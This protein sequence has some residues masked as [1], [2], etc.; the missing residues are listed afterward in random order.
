MHPRALPPLALL[1]VVLA[2]ALPAAAGAATGPLL[3]G[4]TA[5][6]PTADQN[7]AGRAEA[8][9]ASAT[10]SGTVATV[11]V[12]VDAGSPATKLTA[13]IYADSAGKPGALLAQGT[14]DAPVAARWNDVAVT[15]TTLTSGTSYW[16]AILSP[17]GSGALRFRDRAGGG[18]SEASASATLTGLPGTWASGTVYNDS[19]VSAY[20]SAAASTQPILAVAPTSLTFTATTGGADPAAQSV[21]VSN[22]GGG[23]LSFTDAVDSPWLSAT[24]GSGTAPAT[25]SVAPHVAGLAA[26]T[27]NGKVTVTATGVQGSP[28]DVA[29][30]LTVTDPAPPPPPP[31]PSGGDWLQIQHDAARTGFASDE[32]TLTAASAKRLAQAWATAV[33]GK[34]TAA[35]LFVSAI[36]AGGQ[37]RD[38]VVVATAGDSLYAVDAAT[39]TVV[40]RRN[41]GAVVSNCAIPGGF[42]ISASPAID[43]ARGRI[44]T[45]TEDGRLRTVA[46]ADGTDA[47]PAVALV[48][49]P[50]TNRV[51]GGLTLVGSHLYVSTA[52][53][54]CDT[55]PWRGAVY[56]VDVSGASPSPT[57]SWTVVPGIAAPNGGGGIWGYGGVSAD[58]ATGRVYG[59]TG[60]DSAEGYQLYADRLVALDSSLSLLGSWEPTHPTSFP[61][62]GAPCDVDFGA[63]PLVFQPSGCP[64]MVAA[65][66]KDGLLYVSKASTLAAGGAPEQQI[67]LNPAN[68]W[69]G[70]GGVGGTPAWWPDGRTV[71]VSE[72]GPGVTGVNGGV[73]ALS[74]GADCSLSVAWSKALGVAPNP[75]STPTV[76]NGVVYVGEGGSGRTVAFDAQTGEQLWASNGGGAA[77]AAPIV[78]KGTVFQGT[79]DGSSSGDKGTLRAFRPTATAAGLLLGDQSVEAQPDS[80]PLGMAE[81]FQATAS[82]SGTLSKLSV[83]LDTNNSAARLVVG[84]YTDANNHPGSLVVQ[85]SIGSLVNGAF[86]DVP[87]AGGTLVSATKYWIAVLGG[88]SGTLRFRDRAGGCRSETSAQTTLTALP[89]TWSTGVGYPDCPLSG[90]GSGS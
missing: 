71:F 62:N 3:V 7:A 86:N 78:A 37:T 52:S 21:G 14:L 29:V 65:G 1:L 89:A 23:T 66:N 45:V 47:A 39:G 40:W 28:A 85:G 34:I 88:T 12:Y 82:A 49:N 22:A 2:A 53:D 84:V 36:A 6:G 54:G 42:G 55:P 50:A 58:A 79:W 48:P 43:R 73:V 38:L 68:D 80:V 10:A 33:D 46:L 72:T 11:S 75:D 15:A 19:P 17:S 4:T 56:N 90:Y 16:L 74:V 81:A 63:T 57:S 83:Y 18:R 27:Y 44:Y 67:R 76:A 32:T 77:Y 35:P 13:G 5:L 60:A 61:C 9:K 41:F 24:P 59:A 69:L 64:T 30:K 25:I 70:S 51:W 8:F 20:A 31:P 87:V 26:G